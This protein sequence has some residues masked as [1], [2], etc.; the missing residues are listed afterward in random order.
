[1][2]RMD[3]AAVYKRR[4]ADEFPGD[5]EALEALLALA[6]L[7]QETGA[8]D[9]ALEIY[10]DLEGELKTAEEE[11]ELLYWRGEIHFSRSEFETSIVEFKKLYTLYPNL[12]NWS[13]T[14]ELRTAKALALL[15]RTA[16]ARDIL[17]RI[18]ATRG[19]EDN[20][21]LMAQQDLEALGP[22]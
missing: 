15:G 8:L 12:G 21:G 9:D 10:D 5:E 11:A 7:K 16:E 1:M 19:T 6:F 4:I 22:E 13:V 18:V 17:E 2:R 3:S 20:F 14:A